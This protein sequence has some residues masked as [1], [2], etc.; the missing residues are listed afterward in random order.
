ME[1]IHNGMQVQSSDI[2]GR[3]LYRINVTDYS[4]QGLYTCVAHS[5]DGSNSTESVGTLTIVGEL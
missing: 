2:C 1:L 5:A 4:D 3:L